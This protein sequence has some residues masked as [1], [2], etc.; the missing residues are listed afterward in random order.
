MNNRS[1]SPLTSAA[2]RHSLAWLFASLGLVFLRALPNIRYPLGRDQATYC[3]IARGLLQGRILYPDLWDIKPPGIYYIYAVIV[4]LFGPVMWS[5]GVVD[6]VWLLAISL[7]IFHFARR[8]VGVPAAAIAVVLNAMWHCSWGYVNAAQ[9][10]TF[11]VL[12]VFLAYFILTSAQRE[13]R[14]GNF[15]AGLI[16]GAA[17]WVKYNAATFFPILAFLPYLD[18][19]RMDEHPLRLRL[20]IPWSRWIGRTAVFFAGFLLMVAAVLIYFWGVGG[21]PALQEDHFAVLPDYGFMLVHRMRHYPVFALTMIRLHLGVWPVAAFAAAVVIAW[22]QREMRF[23]APVAMM[24][25]AGFACTASQPRF[26]SYSFETAYPFFAMLWGYVIVKLYEGFV[27]LRGFFVRRRWRVA[28]LLLWLVAAE[29]VYYP[30]P[31]YCFQISEEYKELAG[32]MHDP[33]GSYQQYPF[34][35]Y[36]E[37]LHDQMAIIDYL[38]KNSAPGD[39]VYVLGTAALINFLTERPNP[40]RFVT[41]HAII[42]PWGPERW[43]QDLVAELNRTPPRFIVVERHDAI[44]IVTLTYD[45]SEQW[46]KKYPPLASF[47]GSHYESV[48]N[49]YDFEVYRHMEP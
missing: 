40:S 33:H 30:L 13:N 7:C 17:F 32:W 42:S 47:V 15:A 12:L 2:S 26:S 10:E 9:A 35:L 4:K 18:F 38:Q 19:S 44:P 22:R 41:D 27:S 21:W 20:E 14:R 25:A 45:D 29:V 24:A 31:G 36:H 8:Y 3:E 48:K 39:G 23:I 37:K 46:L 6:V 49:L 1:T 5:V 43:R 34:Q 28:N 11:I 16:C